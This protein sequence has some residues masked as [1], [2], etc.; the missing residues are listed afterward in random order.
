MGKE[1]GSKKG[2]KEGRRKGRQGG[3]EVGRQGGREVERVGRFPNFPVPSHVLG[4]MSP[5]SHSI[6]RLFVDW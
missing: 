4:L 2:G 3:R 6:A 5:T 1:A